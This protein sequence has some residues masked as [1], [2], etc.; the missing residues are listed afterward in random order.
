[1]DYVCPTTTPDHLCLLDTKESFANAVN[2]VINTYFTLN[3]STTVHQY[4][5][6]CE[7]KYTIQRTIHKLQEKEMR[8]VEK[9]VGVLQELENANILGCLLAHED[10]IHDMLLQASKNKFYPI[11]SQ[12][13]FTAYT[14]LAKFFK[15]TITQSALNICLNRWHH[16]TQ[17]EIDK[18]LAKIILRQEEDSDENTFL[19]RKIDNAKDCLC[20]RLHAP[21]RTKTHTKPM[22]KHKR[23]PDKTTHFIKVCYDCGKL[24]HI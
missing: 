21:C 12:D 24:G 8:Y 3:L 19:Q 18:F 22:Y 23:L 15:G 13:P 1:M 9:A 16:A 10:K 7:I 17:A 2:H 14:V 5:H 4:Q 6:F 20:S 11:S